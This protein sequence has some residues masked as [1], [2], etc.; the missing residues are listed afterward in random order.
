MMRRLLN[1]FVLILDKIVYVF[2]TSWTSV[3]YQKRQVIYSIP[4]NFYKMG[5]KPRTGG[6][7][8]KSLKSRKVP[9]NKFRAH[10]ALSKSTNVEPSKK[11]QRERKGNDFQSKVLELQQRL[12]GPKKTGR[13]GGNLNIKDATFT[14]SKREQN[15]AKEVQEEPVRDLVAEL[16]AGEEFKLKAAHKKSIY[17]AKVSNNRFGLL[18]NDEILE[19]GT[20]SIYKMD[21]KSPTFALPERK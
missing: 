9:I 3:N 2:V 8:M 15:Q 17:H 14:L 13:K 16:L 20:H 11:K 18:E 4:L 19:D 6:G 7:T 1:N 5:K 21:V 12:S 10:N